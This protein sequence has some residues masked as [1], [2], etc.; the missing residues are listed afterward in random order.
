MA[1]DYEC[2]KRLGSESDSEGRVQRRWVGAF[3]AGAF[4]VINKTIRQLGAYN[5]S[6]KDANQRIKII[7][8]VLL[9]QHN[10]RERTP[11]GKLCMHILETKKRE[12]NPIAWQQRYLSK[13]SKMDN[14]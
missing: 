7:Q 9:V 6:V 8:P 11:A 12:R 14:Y 4:R 13:L 1:Y 3:V 5:Q 10:L 2:R